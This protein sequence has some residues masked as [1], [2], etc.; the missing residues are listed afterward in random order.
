MIMTNKKYLDQDISDS[1]A[2]QE[3]LKPIE[4]LLENKFS[5]DQEDPDD[6]SV[7]ATEKKLLINSFDSSFDTD[8]PIDTISLDETDNEGELLEESGQSKD[9]FGNDLDDNLIEEEDEETEGEH[10]Q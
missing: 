6:S 5:A 10:Q 9:L 7:T 4:S 8:L 3:K 2:D 1:P